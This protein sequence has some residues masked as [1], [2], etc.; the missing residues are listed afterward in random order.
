[1]SDKKKSGCLKWV[2]IALGVIVALV[3]VLGIVATLWLGP[4]VK[5][6]IVNAAPMLGVKADIENV[7]IRPLSGNVVITDLQV[8]NPEGYTEPHLFTIDKFQVKIKPTSLMGDKPLVIEKVIIHAPEFTYEVTGGK[9]NLD[10]LMAKLPKS[11]KEEKEETPKPKSDKP[12][13]KIVIKHIEFFDG[14]VNVRTGYTLGQTIPVPMPGFQLNNIGTEEDG[15]TPVQAAS[16]VGGAIISSITDVVQKSAELIS[17]K[18]RELA[19][20]AKEAAKA[21]LESGKEAAKSAAET[22]KAALE[23]GKDAAKDALDS[24][25]ESLDKTKDAIKGLGDDLKKIF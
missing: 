9:S 20:H 5:T 12:A 21:A 23:S 2:V 4:V 18:A 3:I 25:K 10:T 17:E 15:V 24:G 22:G 11:E 19:G 8:T 6:V 7:H 14:Q 1:M 13:K 16:A